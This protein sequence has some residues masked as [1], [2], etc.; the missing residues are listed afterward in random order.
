MTKSKRGGA[1]PGA[2]RKA[3]GAP[4]TEQKNLRLDRE[5]VARAKAIGDGNLSEGVRRA[6]KSYQD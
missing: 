1:R 5:T 6:V 3:D 4:K 2:G